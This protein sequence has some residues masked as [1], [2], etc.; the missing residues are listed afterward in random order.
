MSDICN[1][2]VAFAGTKGA[3]VAAEVIFKTGAG[4]S[5]K[6]IGKGF[7]VKFSGRMII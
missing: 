7:P 2:R 3:P 1:R 5:G 6:T 4:L